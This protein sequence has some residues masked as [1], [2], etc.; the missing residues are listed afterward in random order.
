MSP[1]TAHRAA[2]LSC[3]GLWAG[4]M[5][6]AH[7]AAPDRPPARLNIVFIL[8]DDQRYDTLGFLGHPIV[9]T[10]HLDRLAREGVHCANAFVTTSLCSPSRASILTGQYM[11]THGVVDNISGVREALAT[12]PQLLQEGGYRTGFF[13]KWHMGAS[14]DPQR[15]FHRWVSF[16]GQGEYQATRT[17]PKAATNQLNVDGRWVARRGYITDELT[18]YAVEWLHSVPRDQP[19]LLYLA[20]KAAHGL[21][22]P[23]ERHRG[24]Y[25]GKPLPQPASR[26]THEHA[27]MWVRNQRNSWH[28]VEYPYHNAD[29]KF[30]EAEYQRYLECLLAVDDS[31]GR[32]M[33]E[34]QTRGQLDDTLILFTSDNGFSFGEH[35]LI[36]KRVAYEWSIRVPLLARCP[37]AF[38]GGRTLAAMVANIDFAPTILEAAGRPVPAG[39]D[40]RSFWPL[41]RGEAGPRRT[42]LLY[43]YYWERQYPQTPTLHALRGERYKYIRSQGVWDLDEL[44]DLRED[45]GETR[46]LILSA[47]HTSLVAEMDQRLTQLLDQ[48]GGLMLPLQ[49]TRGRPQ[50]LRNQEGSAPAGF[51]AEW[52]RPAGKQE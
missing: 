29:P 35:G 51:P 30:W 18:D 20:H 16:R 27:P 39:L 4:T 38:P 42:E 15:G 2:I 13:G 1:L 45:P 40:G 24:R 37:A 48:G 5:R 11:H 44:Y 3:L 25:A 17:V 23:A 34:L 31:V 22:E 7:A 14:A 33:A 12:F 8:T 46:N 49:R 41:L 19:F 32:L 10:P 47:A 36:D 21:C 9:E 26:H 52:I 50:N 43:E 6:I 28:G